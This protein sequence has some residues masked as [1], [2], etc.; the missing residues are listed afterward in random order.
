MITYFRS[1]T[2]LNIQKMSDMA[3]RTSSFDGSSA[4]MFGKTYSGDVPAQIQTQLMSHP[5]S[6]KV[7]LPYV[8]EG[9]LISQ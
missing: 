8:R 5:H 9:D 2:V 1:T 7:M 3:P 6:D 4:K